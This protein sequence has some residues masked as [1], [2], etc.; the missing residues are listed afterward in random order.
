MTVQEQINNLI[1]EIWERKES[2]DA[3]W[4]A[5][6]RIELVAWLPNLND[7]IAEFEHEYF[8]VLQ[9]ALAT[10]PVFARA[11][12]K[13]KAGDEY[14]RLKQAQGLER[15]VIEM[16]RSINKFIKIKEA[17]YQNN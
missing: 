2:W 11:Q 12:A 10:E 9:L 4:L 5:E 14:K 3:Q 17:E 6:K 8:S 15:S 1:Q 13:C 7:K 16:I